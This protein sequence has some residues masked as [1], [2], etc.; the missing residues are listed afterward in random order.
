ME[1]LN[2]SQVEQGA[3]GCYLVGCLAGSW[4]VSVV[5]ISLRQMNYDETTKTTADN[6][7]WVVSAV[8]I[9][10]RQ[11]NYGETTKTTADDMPWEFPVL[12]EMA[13]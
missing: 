10:L 3:G 7:S 12:S 8:L 9:S 11:M 4:V 2:G 5:P 1:G 13:A 6:M